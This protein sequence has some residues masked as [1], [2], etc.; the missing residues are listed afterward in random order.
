MLKKSQAN[1]ARLLDIRVNMSDCLNCGAVNPASKGK[2][3]RKY[4]CDQCCKAFLSKKYV[5]EE[6]YYTRQNPNRGAKAASMRAR[7]QR[8][9]EEWNTWSAI[10]LTR[11]QLAEKL[12]ISKPALH[13][14]IRS[15]EKR[16]VI[17]DRKSLQCGSTYKELINPEDID[18]LS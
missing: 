14:R 10:W 1:N 3:S 6:R 18:K 4:C 8:A 5:A 7:K 17:I 2:R 15:A 9:I 11:A 13:C 12:G 16:G